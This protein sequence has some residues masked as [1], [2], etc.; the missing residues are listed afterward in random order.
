MEIISVVIKIAQKISPLKYFW[1]K[2]NEIKRVL[3]QFILFERKGCREI[4][5]KSKNH[6]DKKI[7]QLMIK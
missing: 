7:E 3:I 6:F 5:V 1:I 4:M 2:M